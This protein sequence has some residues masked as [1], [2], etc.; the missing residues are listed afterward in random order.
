MTDN[1]L[2]MTENALEMTE[3]ALNKK[4]KKRVQ[5]RDKFK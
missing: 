4:Q 3:N 5:Y 2:E 1:A